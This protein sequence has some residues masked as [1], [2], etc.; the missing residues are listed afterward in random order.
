M[1]AATKGEARARVREQRVR[2]RRRARH[3]ADR[4]TELR[5][6]AGFGNLLAYWWALGNDAESVLELMLILK[7]FWTSQQRAVFRKAIKLVAD[8][9]PVMIPTVP[10][11]VA[12]T[13]WSCNLQIPENEADLFAGPALIERGS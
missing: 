10:M 4:V 13:R 11:L 6:I 5:R 2:V 7:P 12:L 1:T 9:D 3:Q 8:D